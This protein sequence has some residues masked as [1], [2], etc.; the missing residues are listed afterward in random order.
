MLKNDDYIEINIAILGSSTTSEI[1]NI[2]ELFLLSNGIK[3]NNNAAS[4]FMCRCFTELFPLIRK[5]IN[6]EILERDFVETE[7]LITE[8]Q[9]SSFVKKNCYLIK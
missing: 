8:W 4:I 6:V 2:L 7:V 3:P 9:K 1:K 5:V